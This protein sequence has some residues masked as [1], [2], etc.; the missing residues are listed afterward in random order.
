LLRPVLCG[1]S[2]ELCFGRLR[3][4]KK[5]V[6]LNKIFSKT[7]QKSAKRVGR[8]GKRGTFSGRG[9]KG[10]KSRSNTHL[11]PNYRDFI[12][13]LPKKRGFK[14]KSFYEKPKAVN[15]DIINENFANGEIVSP[16]TLLEKALISRIG[17]KDRKVKILGNGEIKKKITIKNCLISKSAKAKIE[18]A[19]GTIMQYIT[20]SM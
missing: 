5:N 18:K 3:R 9:V 6:Q 13:K 1:A 19:G 2:Q 14:F 8:G 17:G 15:L 16:K 10:Q 4:R 12:K 7:K 20:H 11:R